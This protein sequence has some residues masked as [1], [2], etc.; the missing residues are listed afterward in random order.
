MI[1]DSL[2]G[3]IAQTAEAAETGQWQRHVAARW[4]RQALDGRRTSGRWGTPSGF[5]VLYLGR[6]T[7][8][9]VVEAYRRLVDPVDAEDAERDML[10]E[11]LAP[12]VLVTCAVAV[13]GLLDLR[14]AGARG[15]VGLTLQDL[16]SSTA[17]ESAYQRCREVAQVAHQL[18]R[19]GVLAPAATGLGE[20]L[21][22]FTDLLPP[23][24]RPVRSAPDEA[25]SRLPDDPRAQPA[26]RLRVVPTS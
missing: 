7:D 1:G 24:E 18:G 23:Q 15:L 16:T 2:A 8:S 22:L 25:W 21:A 4:S 20:T 19:R 10:L 3:R 13:T 26:R 14:S 11:G 17:D 12:R 5:P 9:V 6:P